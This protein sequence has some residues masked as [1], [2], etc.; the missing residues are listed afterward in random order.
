MP[1]HKHGSGIGD[2]WH[3]GEDTRPLTPLGRLV[4]R[5]SPGRTASRFA[6]QERKV[7]TKSSA[8][9]SRKSKKEL[10]RRLR[11]ADPGLEVVHPDAA[12]ID[13]GNESHYVAVRPDRDP[14]PVPRF[15]CFTADLYRTAE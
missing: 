6:D 8:E 3:G 13:I 10:T 12:G 15:A 4:N 9:V 1:D 5:S 14:E 11:S 7:R 2:H